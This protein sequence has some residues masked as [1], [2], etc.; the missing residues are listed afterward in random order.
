MT[1]MPER[2]A[3]EPAGLYMGWGD[4]A[5]RRHSTAG[6]WDVA[7]WLMHRRLVGRGGIEED[8]EE[9]EQRQMSRKT[10]RGGGEGEIQGAGER[11]GQG[12]RQ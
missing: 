3:W 2:R 12:G 1:M 11:E 5:T 9:R 8:R 10:S 7:G 6:S 4:E